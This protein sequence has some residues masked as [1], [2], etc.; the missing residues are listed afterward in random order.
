MLISRDVILYAAYVV[1]DVLFVAFILKT[2]L[3]WK[4][5]VMHLFSTLSKLNQ[6]YCIYLLT[7]HSISL[8]LHFPNC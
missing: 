5:V 4:I 6:V 7:C 1:S 8:E 2:T 3:L